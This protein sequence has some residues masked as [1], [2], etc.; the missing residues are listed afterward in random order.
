MKFNLFAVGTIALC[1]LQQIQAE[2]P[3]AADAVTNT[4]DEKTVDIFATKFL[5]AVTPQ[6]TQ[7]IENALADKVVRRDV[8]GSVNDGGYGS[9]GEKVTHELLKRGIINGGDAT[10]AVGGDLL[11]LG[12]LIEDLINAIANLEQ[13]ILKKVI[14]DVTKL[15]VDVNGVVADLVTIVQSLNINKLATDVQVVV[16]NLLVN[17]AK[18]LE[19]LGAEVSELSEVI[20]DVLGE[21]ITKNPVTGD[22]DITVNNVLELVTS[23]LDDVNRLLGTVNLDGLLQSVFNLVQNLVDNIIKLDGKPTKATRGLLRR[24]LIKRAAARNAAL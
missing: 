19:F 23:I 16:K 13:G 14:P 10:G 7:V 15:V 3:S 21:V 20:D 17:V 18:L 9:L 1:L 6:L 11:G 22:G 4:I 2:A 12:P 8:G 24:N 5:E